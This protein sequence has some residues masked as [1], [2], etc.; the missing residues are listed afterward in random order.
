MNVT[1]LNFE[2]ITRVTNE[3]IF[4]VSLIVAVLI[5]LLILIIV[6]SIAMSSK[7]I[8]K[9]TLFWIAFADYFILQPVLFILLVIFP[10]WRNWI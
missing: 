9:S 1:T 8:T 6:G 3:P 10:F 5:P 2:Q 7:K 4:L